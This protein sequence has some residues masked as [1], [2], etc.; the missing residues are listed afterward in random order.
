MDPHCRDVRFVPKA[1]ICSAAKSQLFNH[2]VG[3]ARSEIGTVIPSALATLR[4]M[5]IVTLPV[6]QAAG[7]VF[8]P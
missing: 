3:P 7:R 5:T 8:R 6:A 1:N 4:L 2:L